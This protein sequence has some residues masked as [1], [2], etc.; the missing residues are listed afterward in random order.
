MVIWQI[1]LVRSR[2]GPLHY[3]QPMATEIS[4][5]FE[6]KKVVIG[7]LIWLFSYTLVL[8]LLTTFVPLEGA[9]PA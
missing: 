3:T 1:V 8:M 4:I 2:V 7:H 5:K 9:V 6:P